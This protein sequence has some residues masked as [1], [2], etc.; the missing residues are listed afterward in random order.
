MLWKNSEHLCEINIEIMYCNMM[1]DFVE[2]NEYIE[3]LKL[4]IWAMVFSCII[5]TV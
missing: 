5:Y 2:I 1:L 3:K 4:F